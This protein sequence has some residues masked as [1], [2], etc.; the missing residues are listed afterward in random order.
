MMYL[1]IG[2]P[3]FLAP[4]LNLATFHRWTCLVVIYLKIVGLCIHLLPGMVSPAA[5]LVLACSAFVVAPVFHGLPLM[6]EYVPLI[7]EHF[8]YADLAIFW[9]LLFYYLLGFD[10]AQ[11]VQSR[12]KN[13]S[14]SKC[15][16]EHVPFGCA[17]VAAICLS[18]GQMAW[19]LFDTHRDRPNYF[20]DEWY[21]LRMLVEFCLV[22]FLVIT[23]WG[24][25]WVHEMFAYLGKNLVGTY[26]V[27]LYFRLDLVA[28]L[29]SAALKGGDVAQLALLLVV[30][31]VYVL[32]FGFLAQQLL[33]G[34]FLVIAQMQRGFRPP[35]ASH[36]KLDQID[37]IEPA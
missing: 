21:P 32:S 16:C 20:S 14:W 11:R 17:I 4:S 8:Q 12:L 37:S 23:V 5:A 6:L 2:L 31:V 13:T 1:A 22:V 34:M 18:C 7:G 33:I 27:H 29:K 28:L 3:G 24:A 35:K 9:K 36:R 25:S 26:L 19:D 10:V 30:P 15:G